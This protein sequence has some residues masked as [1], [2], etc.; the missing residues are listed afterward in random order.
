MKN[1]FP[2]IVILFLIHVSITKA[3]SLAWAFPDSGI[4]WCQSTRWGNPTEASGGTDQQIFPDGSD[5]LINGLIYY[6]LFHT[7]SR[8]NS[9]PGSAAIYFTYQP[10]GFFRNDTLNE[11]VEFRRIYEDPII[12]DFNLNVG[13]TI[14][15]PRYPEMVVIDSISTIW[16]GGLQRRIYFYEWWSEVGYLIEG[17]GPY[18]GLGEAAFSSGIIDY[19]ATL[20]CLT[21]NDSSYSIVHSNFP[22]ALPT[23]EETSCDWCKGIA[24]YTT[25]ILNNTPFNIFPNPATD[26]VIIDFNNTHQ[27]AKID[28]LNISGQLI[29]SEKNTTTDKKVIDV[30]DFKA[31]IYFAII[32]TSSGLDIKKFQ[33]IR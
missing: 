16:I 2:A 32:K 17:L 29:Y 22:T 10:Y 7:G 30:S 31:G 13:D 24:V 20:N 27:N 33:I 15:F 9:I 26:Q 11:L 18:T 23:Y 14:F 1:K 8:Y 28:I 4:V 5:T 25:N 3:Q 6:K 19:A 21:I 12:Y